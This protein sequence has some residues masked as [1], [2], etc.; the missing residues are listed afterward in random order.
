MLTEALVDFV[1]SATLIA[2]TVTE[3]LEATLLGAVY[4]PLVEIVP[5]VE[6]PPWTP[7]TNHV[8]PVLEV[9]LTLATNCC[10]RPGVRAAVVGVTL[11]AT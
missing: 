11:T 3:M 4:R 5:V 10:F 7:L 2:V 6:L 9:P 1:V 8:T